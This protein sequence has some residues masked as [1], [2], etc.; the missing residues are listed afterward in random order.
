MDGIE[1]KLRADIEQYGWHVLNVLPG[2]SHPPHS[3]SVGLFAT[4][5]HPEIVVVGLPGDTAHHLINNLAEEIKEGASFEAGCRYGH[6]LEGYDVMFV[7]VA[8]ENYRTYFGR[9]LDYYGS[10]SFS[11]LQMVWPD[12]NRFFPWDAGCAEDIRKLQPVLARTQ[13]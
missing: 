10:I 7:R 9:A 4:F 11:I 6:V 2:D 5:D 1:R 3:Y 13:R 8:P 12:R